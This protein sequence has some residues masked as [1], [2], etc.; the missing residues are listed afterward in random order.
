MPSLDAY[1][2]LQLDDSAGVSAFLLAHRIRHETY[3]QAAAL[4]GVA[5]GV[6]QL[7]YYPDDTWFLTHGSAHQFLLQFMP[8]DNSVDMTVLTA[9]SWDNQGDFD[10]WMQMHTLI[11]QLLDQHFGIF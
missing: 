9:Y 2:G 3:G 5:S 6:Y 4:A 8:S 7:G 11:H 1:Q 10:T